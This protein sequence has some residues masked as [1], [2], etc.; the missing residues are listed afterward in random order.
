[1]YQANQISG[2]REYRFDQVG[3]LA[4]N[5][6]ARAGVYAKV[7]RD[8]GAVIFDGKAQAAQAA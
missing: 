6:L 4:A 8:T 7:D 2:V 5:I 1:M 3:S